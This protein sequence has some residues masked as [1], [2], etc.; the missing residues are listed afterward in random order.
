MLFYMGVIGSALNAASVV[1]AVVSAWFWMTASQ[2]PLP[3]MT[4]G[5]NWDGS[6]AFPD[7]LRKQARHNA[8]AA[9]CAAVAA[10]C[11][12]AAILLRLVN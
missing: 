11:Q 9:A 3:N 5:T 10:G 8:R 4:A 6:G 12:A 2:V 1:A 7:A